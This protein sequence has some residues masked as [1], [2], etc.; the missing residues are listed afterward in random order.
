MKK[1]NLFDQHIKVYY[2]YHDVELCA[3]CNS[4]FAHYDSDYVAHCS[5]ACFKLDE[6]KH[7]I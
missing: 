6:K 2:L 3:Y 1:E 7:N 5:D 4:P